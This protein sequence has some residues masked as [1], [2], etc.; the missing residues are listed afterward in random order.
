MVVN[1]DAFGG[2]L[3]SPLY[4]LGAPVEDPGAILSS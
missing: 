4:A 3:W 2:H 1:S